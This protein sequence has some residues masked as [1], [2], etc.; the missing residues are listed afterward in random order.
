MYTLKRVGLSVIVGLTLFS[1]GYFYGHYK[2][3]HETTINYERSIRDA[4]IKREAKAKA[5]WNARQ[6]EL[7]SI[8]RDH[9]VS[10]QELKANT[11]SIIDGLNQSNKRLYV[12]VKQL[13]GSGAECG[14]RATDG[15]AELHQDTVRHLVSEA[16][17]ADRWVIDLQRT[18][19][20]LQGQPKEV[21]D[22][23]EE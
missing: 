19:R 13:S 14:P 16:Q 8:S 11:D 18:V 22:A 17:R 23:E 7:N 1:G 10:L 6:A 5:D 12:K 21:T 2:G 4:D 20:A 9:A 15:Y 3:V